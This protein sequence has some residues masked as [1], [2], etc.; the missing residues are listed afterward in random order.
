MRRK[1]SVGAGGCAVGGGRWAVEEMV[2]EEVLVEEVL[3]EEGGGTGR[4]A[5]S[6]RS[7]EVAER[8]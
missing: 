6:K 5:A 4:C 3:V 1:E 8:E 7:G 2:V